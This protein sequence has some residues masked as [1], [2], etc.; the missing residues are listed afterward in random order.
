[1]GIYDRINDNIQRI[2][3]NEKE[4]SNLRASYQESTQAREKKEIMQRFETIM[5]NNRQVTKKIQGQLKE[6]KQ[7]NDTYSSEHI[8]SSVAQ[9]RV[10][11][12]NSCTRQFKTSTNS[13]Q[14][15]LT[16]F[17][18][19]LKKTQRRQIGVVAPKSMTTEEQDKLAEN[20][21]AA[22]QFLKQQFDL[23]DVN[24]QML[25]RL[26]ELEARH[27]GM[28]KIEQE[29]KELQEMWVELHTLIME[30]QELL[31]NIENNVLQTRDYVQ[32]GVKHIT[33]AEV[34]QK[35]S[36]KVY[37]HFIFYILYV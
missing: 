33:K 12:L 37:L 9:W 16:E 30:Q 28:L 21:E 15:E 35:Q 10:N 19:V 20:Y 25:D 34:H 11:Q 13:Y 29:V 24:D 32:S 23:T 2:E 27:N 26:A 17:Q 36:R 31:D 14:N 7:N 8:G 1:M 22:D 6:E 3:D 4:I 18:N 5:T